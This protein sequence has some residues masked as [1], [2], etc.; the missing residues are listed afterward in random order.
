MRPGRFAAHTPGS[1]LRASLRLGTR[2]T[3]RAPTTRLGLD[4]KSRDFPQP[5]SVLG[6]L[7]RGWE[8]TTSGLYAEVFSNPVWR[9]R[10][11]PA[12]ARQPKG[13]RAGS[14]RVAHGTGTCRC[15]TCTAKARSAGYAHHPGGLLFGYFLL[16]GQ[17]K[18]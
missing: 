12:F 9:A 3:R 14:P 17:E 18:V 4:Q 8:Q 6:S 2:L 7:R 11:S 16:A 10:A 13:A 1:S 15:A 5:C